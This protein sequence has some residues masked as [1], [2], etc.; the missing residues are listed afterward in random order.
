[1]PHRLRRS[2]IALGSVAALCVIT[3]LSGSASA[4]GSKGIKGDPQPEQKPFRVGTTDGDGGNVAVLANGDMVL[5]YVIPTKN[6]AGAVRVCVLARGGH[7]CTHTSTLNTLSD[8]D[9]FDIPQ[10]FALSDNRVVVLTNTCCDDEDSTVGDDLLFTSS[11]GGASFGSAVRVGDVSVSAATVVGS[12]IV[13]TGGNA[14]LGAQVE[15]VSTTAPAPP[16]TTALVND[17]QPV[18]V[19]IGTY[20]GGALV[21]NDVDGEKWVTNVEY[22]PSGSDFNDSSA[23]PTVAS[24]PNEEL[25]GGS[26]NAVLTIQTTGKELVLVRYFNGTKFG[27]PVAVPGFKDHGIGYWISIDKDPSGVTHVFSESSFSTPGYHLFETSTKTGSH[28]SK[29]F[30]LG[31]AIDYSFFGA[32]LD[33][34]GTGLVLGTGHS[35]AEGFPVLAPQSVTF[36]LKK[37]SL[38]KGHKTTGSGKATVAAHG[39]KV[40]LQVERSHHL[41]YNVASTHES[42][43][44][45]FTFTIKGTSAGKFDYRAVAADHAGY[46][47]FG[48]SA[49][50]KL[51]VR[52]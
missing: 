28:W 35:R 49:A 10:V 27:A 2:A 34:N 15:S 45:K 19:S 11:N 46:V 4:I 7:T 51:T 30:D 5:A 24:F 9:V 21:G 37:S 16:V 33:A 29:P 40:E 38:K 20:K 39:R 18:D 36:A 41:W 32:G 22:A 26:G 6:D 48:Y 52:S 13:F 1:M 42:A 43:S 25:I 31:D 8:D 23:Y 47:Q 12:N 17:N 44:G 14:H 50:R 3:A